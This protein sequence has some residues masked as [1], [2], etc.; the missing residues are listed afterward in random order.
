MEK[1]ELEKVIEKLEKLDLRE[2]KEKKQEP[3]VYEERHYEFIANING[4]VF[5]IYVS[6]KSREFRKDLY[7]PCLSITNN[8]GT[9]RIDYNS[10]KDIPSV[11]MLRFHKK[12]KDYLS[13][14]FKE[15]Q[16]KEFEERLND[17]LS[18]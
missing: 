17:F 14:D 9:M 13:D 11:P 12:I 5:S 3:I 6:R 1:P 18:G 10:E 4:L 2:W 8:E 7:Y 16:R 15:K